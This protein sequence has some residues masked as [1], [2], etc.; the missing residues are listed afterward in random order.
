M[1]S[2]QFDHSD[3]DALLM[4]QFFLYL[5]RLLNE[6]DGNRMR[7]LHIRPDQSR[8][9]SMMTTADLLLL[10]NLGGHCIDFEID[11]VA[12]DEVLRQL[13]EKKGQRE[14]IN[15]CIQCDAPKAMMNYFFGM[16][17][18]TY[19]KTRQ[20]L[21]VPARAGRHRVLDEQTSNRIYRLYCE[22]GRQFLPETLLY[23]AEA[24]ETPLR[25]IWDEINE[26]ELQQHPKDPK[27][28][29]TMTIVKTNVPIEATQS[30]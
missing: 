11:E 19:S 22:R 17:G 26:I 9:I 3:N 21:N 28:A 7:R 29:P 24:L 10:G 18:R 1:N 4:Q 16:S 8:R 6:H 30:A 15:R 5:A 25:L 2:R 12:L 27:P 23:I 14:L 20:A 13:D